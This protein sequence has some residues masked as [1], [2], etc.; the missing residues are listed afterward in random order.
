MAVKDL[1][2][3][4]A[5][6]PAIAPNVYSASTTPAAIDLSGFESAAVLIEAGVGGV[7]FSSTVRIDFV[8]SDSDD[9]VN[10]SPATKFSG[11][12]LPSGGVTGGVVKSLQAAHATPDVTTIGYIGGK[13]Y[14][15]VQAN[16]VGTQATGTPLSATVVKGN[17]IFIP[18]S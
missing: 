6:V 18:T 15:E 13:R 2:S 16:F 12:E 11:S 14:L 17:P 5:A 4:I 7:T 3:R 10:F 8:V 9:G 1:A